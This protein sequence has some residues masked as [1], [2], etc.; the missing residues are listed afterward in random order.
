MPWAP[1]RVRF[2]FGAAVAL[3]VVLPATLGGCKRRTGDGSADAGAVAD[4]EGGGEIVAIAM[5][6]AGASAGA[7]SVMLHALALVTP[8]LNE[9]EW[10]ARDPSKTSDERK[11]AMR[12]GYLRKG[13]AV[14]ARSQLLKKA[15]CPEGW[16]ELLPPRGA[17]AGSSGG[18]VC[19]KYA[20]LDP[21]DKDLATAPHPPNLA[22]PL[23][24]DYGLNIVDGAPLYTRPPR[25]RERSQYERGLE[26]G[27][28][29]RK[30]SGDDDARGPATAGAD[31]DTA[32]YVD[33]KD[34][35]QNLD[36][37]PEERD[38]AHRAP[39]GQGLLLGARQGGPATPAGRFWRTTHGNFVPKELI[40]VHDPKAEFHGVWL[41]AP[42][43]RAIC[44]S[45]WITNPPSGSTRSADDTQQW[46]PD[47][48]HKRCD[49]GQSVAIAS[50]S[51]L[52]GEKGARRPERVLGDGR[53]LV[54]ARHR[55]DRRP[56]PARR[57]KD[58]RRARSGS[59]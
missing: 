57:P 30:K 44:R 45:G 17:P 35:T 40:L 28:T 26:V 53:R 42:E 55:R 58:S 31:D 37:R 24:Y 15:N 25:P 49:A 56:S 20:T 54:D 6:D 10:P 21:A 47:A 59:T 41:A 16:Y 4:L 34:R 13:D 2:T 48:S 27:R 43:R 11:S 29:S 14:A 39:D 1:A 9:P 46:S 7:A 3:T 52:T 51:C 38:G 23:P 8:V 12:L 22:G 19:G 50:P 5:P 36:G 18:F 32:W 33:H